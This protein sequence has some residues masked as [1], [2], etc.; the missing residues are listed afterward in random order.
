MIDWSGDKE[1]I[2]REVLQVGRDH[3]DRHDLCMLYSWAI[4]TPKAIGFIAF[5][6]A[7]YSGNREVIE[8]GAGRGYWSRMLSEAGCNVHAFD[9]TVETVGGFTDLNGNC[10]HANESQVGLY[11]DVQPGDVDKAGLSR[12]ATLFLCWPPYD[13]PM[14]LD[15]LKAYRGNQLVVVGEMHGGCCAN[16]E[17][18][19]E[20]D[21][22]WT[23]TA[24]HDIPQWPCI[25]DYIA[26][27]RRNG[28]RK[29]SV[30]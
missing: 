23:E 27:F 1:T 8:I 25:H 18:W 4:P 13:D 28:V 9:K 14:A 11:F 6:V 20:L 7:Q 21:K 3:M 22:N 29:F 15:A 12:G 5:H 19:S 30:E 24:T 16:D 26:A 10:Y 17:F 2:D